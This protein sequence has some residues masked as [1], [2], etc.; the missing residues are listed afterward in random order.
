MWITTNPE[1][2]LTCYLCSPMQN[3]PTQRLTTL[4]AEITVPI[5]LLEKFKRPSLVGK[6]TLIINQ[7]STC[8]ISNTTIAEDQTLCVDVQT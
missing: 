2:E 8:L 6:K 7:M 1:C 3:D 5:D 4:C